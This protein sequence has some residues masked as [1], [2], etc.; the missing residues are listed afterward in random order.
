MP[1]AI[2]ITEIAYQDL[3]EIKKFYQQQ[4]VDAM[5][6]QLAHEPTTET[7]NRKMLVDFHAEFEHETP[8]WR[9]RI[10]EFRV[11]YDVNEEQKTVLVRRILQKPPHATTE[12]IA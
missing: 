9:L 2:E 10:G 11:F 1:Y 5:R 4:I 8:V 7:R 6:Q 3:E 12:Q